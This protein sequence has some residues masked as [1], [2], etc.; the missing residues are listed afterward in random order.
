MKKN[1]ANRLVSEIESHL[2][3]WVQVKTPPELCDLPTE[4]SEL[5]YYVKPA[6]GRTW[7][8]VGVCGDL[9][10]ESMS[11]VVGWSD[12]GLPAYLP[13]EVLADRKG[14]IEWHRRGM[15]TNEFDHP[16][17]ERSLGGLVKM[18]VAKSY[19]APGG[20]PEAIEEIIRDLQ[21][22]GVEYWRIMLK[23]RFEIDAADLSLGGQ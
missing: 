2:V 7:L 15:P 18:G 4:F 16:T 11:V 6:M 8:L 13:K 12:E 20:T 23:R 22:V 17:F 21:T 9:R 19:D 5:K 14:Y 10:H 3:G 1:D